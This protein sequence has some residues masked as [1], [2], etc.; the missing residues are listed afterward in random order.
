MPNLIDDLLSRPPLE[1]MMLQYLTEYTLKNSPITNFALT[2]VEL[3]SQEPLNSTMSP[4]IN[5][6]SRNLAAPVL[7]RTVENT[8]NTTVA[9]Q[10]S[11]NLQVKMNLQGFRIYS[12]LI[13]LTDLFL[14]GIDS[15]EFTAELRKSNIFYA[16]A[17]ASS[18]AQ[19]KPSQAD[20]SAPPE[21]SKLSTAAIVIVLV[22][23]AC[24]AV[25]G[26]FFYRK[27]SHILRSMSKKR[28]LPMNTGEM[29]QNP[30]GSGQPNAFSFDLSP[31]SSTGF[32]RLLAVFGSENTVSR[33]STSTSSSSETAPSPQ[34]PKS[35]V[36]EHPLTGIIPPMLVIGNIDKPDSNASMRAIPET[37][38][39]RRKIVVPSRRMDASKSFIEALN[40]HGSDRAGSASSFADLM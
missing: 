40:N 19:A 27:H 2:S 39:S 32:G 15:P 6:T 11:I 36:E 9:T 7:R 33:D 38:R 34:K 24:V 13:V 12:I 3:L 20:V 18:A 16:N 31:Q 17:T 25:F 10:D 28:E 1:N 23:I 29:P 22:V 35:I 8:E 4:R 30:T 37:Q 14:A 5:N 26:I 21:R